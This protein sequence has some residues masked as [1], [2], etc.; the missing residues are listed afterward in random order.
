[1]D[2]PLIFSRGCW[3]DFQTRFT[4]KAISPSTSVRESLHLR[5]APANLKRLY[6]G[7]PHDHPASM[8]PYDHPASMAPYDHPASKGAGTHTA[9]LLGAHFSLDQDADDRPH[10]S[11][12][13]R[14]HCIARGIPPARMPK[15]RP[16]SPAPCEPAGRARRTRRKCYCYIIIS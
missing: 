12:T 1:M 11:D 6:P 5:I 13:T 16:P 10:C 7:A 4:A 3:K 15:P 8:A 9:F 2:H 14:P